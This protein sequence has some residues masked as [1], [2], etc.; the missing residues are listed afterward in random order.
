MQHLRIEAD[1][2]MGVASRLLD[3]LVAQD[4]FPNAMQLDRDG[5]RL[6]FRLGFD[7]ALGPNSPLIARIRQ[8]PGVRRA[9]PLDLSAP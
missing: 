9:T 4:S 1:A 3:L 2:D 6:T 7:R 8:I 5:L